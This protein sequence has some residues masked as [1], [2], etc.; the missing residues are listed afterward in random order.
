MPIEGATSLYVEHEN[1]EKLYIQYVSIAKCVIIQ[2][3]MSP[4]V[5]FELGEIIRE[6]HGEKT[7][8]FTSPTPDSLLIKWIL[9]AN[10]WMKDTELIGWKKFEEIVK[11][12]GFKSKLNPQGGAVITFN[13]ENQTV[14]LAEKC[15]SPSEYIQAVNDY[16]LKRQKNIN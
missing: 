16:L 6:R 13:S 1:W 8:I 5:L 7:F 14:L 11:M 9:A 10:N 3:S 2:P 4:S 12:I 15:K